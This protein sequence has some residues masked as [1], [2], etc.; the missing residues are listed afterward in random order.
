MNASEAIIGRSERNA[1]G[2]APVAPLA[3]LLPFADPHAR[4]NVAVERLAGFRGFPAD[5]A[6]QKR[7]T[8][9]V[10]NAFER[11]SRYVGH[12][13]VCSRTCRVDNVWG[14]ILDLWDGAVH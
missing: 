3:K 13:S 5:F 11:C 4:S 6:A 12:N 8:G 10:D 14:L 1:V 7:L 2:R 9:T